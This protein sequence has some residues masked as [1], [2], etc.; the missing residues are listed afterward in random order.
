MTET[1]RDYP[2]GASVWQELRVRGA[3][4]L[5]EFYRAT[6]GL[7]LELDGDRGYLVTESGDRV[8]GVVVDAELPEA[9]IGW[10]VF[11]GADDLDAAVA[12]ATAGGATVLRRDEPLLIDAPSVW[13]LD[14]FGAPFGLAAPAPG[15]AV[16][17]STELG[18]LVLVDPTNHDIDAQVEF[19]Q[20]LFPS[21]VH[22]PVD[23]H[24]VCFFRN[25]D[26]LALRGSYAVEEAA[27]AVLPPHWLAWFSVADQAAAVDAAAAAGGT[28]NVRDV[29][30]RFGTWGVVVDPSGGV[31][32]TLQVTESGI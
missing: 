8:G 12:R 28:V 16:P 14:P 18:K 1:V 3:E 9:E 29:V 19:Q 24:D 25:E 23:P 13:L 11:L 20:A 22:D 26:G 2:V 10:H 21:N 27:R 4:G 15:A 32:K 30:S 17:G 5:A 6:L 7:K 31:F